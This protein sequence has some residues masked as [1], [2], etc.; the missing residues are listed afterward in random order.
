MQDRFFYE[1]KRKQLEGCGEGVGPATYDS[2][3]SF[4]RFKKQPCPAVIVS[5]YEG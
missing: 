1:R 5:G 3:E 2:I 4:N